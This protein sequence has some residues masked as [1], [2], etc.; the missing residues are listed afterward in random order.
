MQKPLSNRHVRA[1]P[2]PIHG[3]GT[4]EGDE[5][6]RSERV[7]VIGIGYR[8]SRYHRYYL[9]VVLEYHIASHL[10]DIRIKRGIFIESRLPG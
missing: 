1:I 3:D 5:L 6:G 8:V 9:L 2:L 4:S 10:S 7:L